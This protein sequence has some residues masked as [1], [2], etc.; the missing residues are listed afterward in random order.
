MNSSSFSSLVLRADDTDSPY[1]Y[2]PALWICIMFIIL[3]SVSTIAQL[4]H[5]LCVRQWFLLPTVVLAG[6]GEILG[7]IGRLWSNQNLQASDPYMIQIACLIISPTPLL[8]A[9]FIIFGRLVQILGSQYSRFKPTLYSRIF[10]S[11]DI[12]S[13]V[14][15]AVGGGMTASANDDAGVNLGT[16]IMLAGIVIQLA[17]LIIFST[18]ALEFVYRFNTDKPVRSEPS[19]AIGYMDRRRTIG[20]FAVFFATFCLFIRAVYRV[21]ELADGWNGVVISTQWSFDLFDSGMVVLAMYT[22]NFVPVSWILSGSNK[23]EELE[24]QYNTSHEPLN[25]Q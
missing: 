20:L 18:T 14:V 13:L 24:M 6:C 23:Q 19:D 16:N 22:W 5:T 10:L 21:I 15:Q 17:I 25:T 9:H 11:C 12:V 4:L 7:W 3:F 1:G 2:V 8:G